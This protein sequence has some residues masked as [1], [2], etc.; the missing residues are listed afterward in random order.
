MAGRP[1]RRAR[2]ERA[3]R[4]SNS[5]APHAREWWQDQWEEGDYLLISKR[6]GADLGVSGNDDFWDDDEILP[7]PGHPAMIIK[8]I[9]PDVVS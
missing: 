8:I 6:T 7:E 2:R 1:L 4:N 9:N 5:S 3:L